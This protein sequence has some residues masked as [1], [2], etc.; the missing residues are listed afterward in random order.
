MA[1]FKFCVS[2]GYVGSKREEIVEIE[3]EE[4]EGLT[5]DKQEEIVQRYFDEW[6]YK[7]SM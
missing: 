1:R 5:E 2:N 3:D 6:L 7:T 4:L